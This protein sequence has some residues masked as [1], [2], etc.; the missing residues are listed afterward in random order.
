MTMKATTPHHHGGMKAAVPRSEAL[1][2]WDFFPVFPAFDRTMLGEKKG[3][4]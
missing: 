2:E 3:S 4:I 1:E